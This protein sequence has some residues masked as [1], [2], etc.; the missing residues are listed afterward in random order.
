[1]PIFPSKGVA[2]QTKQVIGL[3]VGRRRKFSKPFQNPAG[4]RDACVT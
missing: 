1:M 2:L 4:T 3:A